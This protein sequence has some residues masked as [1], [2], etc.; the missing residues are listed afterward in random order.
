MA[1]HMNQMPSR[2]REQMP[3]SFMSMIDD[4]TNIYDGVKFG[5]LR[6]NSVV[7]VKRLQIIHSPKSPSRIM[8]RFNSDK[9]TGFD[10]RYFSLHQ[11]LLL[12]F[13]SGHLL[14]LLEYDLSLAQ[15]LSPS[16]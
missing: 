11:F 4:K 7:L 8:T 16:A 1:T 6:I 9:L 12:L 15:K 14:E 3:M 13:C 10:S 2:G 5:K